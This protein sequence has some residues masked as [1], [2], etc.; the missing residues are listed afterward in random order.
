MA[1]PLLVLRV[2]SFGEPFDR[3]QASV[4]LGSELSHRLGGLVEAISVYLVK[5]F[6]APFAPADQAGSVKH[7][8][9]LGNPT[10]PRNFDAA[11]S[12]SRPSG[13]R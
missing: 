3:V 6:P 13:R 11:P 10:A 8:Q 4:P 12:E 9:V 2:C 5:D 1:D 7:D